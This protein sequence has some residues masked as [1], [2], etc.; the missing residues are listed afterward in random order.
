MPH[1][2]RKPRLKEYENVPLRALPPEML[3]S[4]NK[5]AVLLRM[6][7]RTVAKLMLMEGFPPPVMVGRFPAYRAG[8]VSQ[9]MDKIGGA[10]V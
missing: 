3:L 10:T 6:N 4:K 5:L 9:Y 7:H 8:A 2:I 1:Q